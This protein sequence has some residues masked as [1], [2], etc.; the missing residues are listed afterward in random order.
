[1]CGVGSVFIKHSYES[2]GKV[3]VIGIEAEMSFKV[4]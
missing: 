1:M 2:S 4:C 3:S